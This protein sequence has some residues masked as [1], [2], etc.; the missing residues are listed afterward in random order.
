MLDQYQEN[1]YQMCDTTTNLPNTP[2]SV[3]DILNIDNDYAGYYCPVKREYED[4]HFTNQSH[5][6]DQ[7]QMSEQ[8]YGY[9]HQEMVQHGMYPVEH[10]YDT[11]NSYLNQI[12]EQKIDS[13]S[14]CNM[15]NYLT[16]L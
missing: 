16:L 12:K 13:P 3:K 10:Q 15:K 1:Q 2:F 8:N 4:D 14:K 9:Y 6:W 7:T 5:F 11:F